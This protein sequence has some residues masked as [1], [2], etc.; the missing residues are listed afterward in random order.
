MQ[1]ALFRPAAHL[2]VT[3]EDAGSYLQGQFSQDLRGKGT[4]YG[5]LL[6]HKGRIQADAFVQRKDDAY[7]ITS[8]FVGAALLRERLESFIV[9]D[10]VVVEDVT[11]R[12][13]GV[14]LLGNPEEQMPEVKIDWLVHPGRRGAAANVDWLAPNESESAMME[15]LRAVGAEPISDVILNRIRVRAG[16]PAVPADAGPGELPQEVGLAENA[17][18]YDKGCYV[19]QEIM[20]RLKTR[21]RVRRRLRRVTAQALAPLPPPGTALWVGDK[22]VGEMRTSVPALAESD[23]AMGLALI[24]GEQPPVGARLGADPAGPAGIALTDP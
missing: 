19:G 12:W 13:I 8:Y 17:V 15:R 24:V 16:I 20:A 14:S 18:A 21:G 1:F 2:R 4:A 3:G 6:N 10:D 7:W 11:D 5:L 9:A 23:P 22:K